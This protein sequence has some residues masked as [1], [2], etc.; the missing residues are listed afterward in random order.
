MLSY[1]NGYTCIFSIH[2][3]HSE[4]DTIRWRLSQTVIR[5]TSVFSRV[6]T[7]HAWEPVRRS[8]VCL[9]HVSWIHYLTSCDVDEADLWCRATVH[10]TRQSDRVSLCG[11]PG[12]CA[13]CWLRGWIWKMY[14]LVWLTEDIFIREF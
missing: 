4:L 3:F 11:L 13:K 9:W 10:S 12:R 8:V 2:T 7:V 14:M 1:C 5:L 6:Q